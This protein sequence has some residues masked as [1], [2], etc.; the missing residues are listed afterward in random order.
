MTITMSSWTEQQIA[1]GT[2]SLGSRRM[3]PAAAAALYDAASGLSVGDAGFLAAPAI[4]QD[5]E[6]RIMAGDNEPRVWIGCFGCYNGGRLV[7]DWY[8]P[9]APVKSSSSKSTPG[10]ASTTRP[11]CAKS[12]G[13]W[14]RT[15]F[16]PPLR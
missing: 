9:P 12:S 16:P 2:L 11:S 5:P 15:T 13:A 4:R 6:V 1:A 14:T 8:P 3:E 10:A 7:G